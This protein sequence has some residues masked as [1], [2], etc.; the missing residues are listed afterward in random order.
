MEEAQGVRALPR[1]APAHG[2]T[3]APVVGGDPGPA[4]LGSCPVNPAFAVGVDVHEDQSFDQVREDELQ[5]ARGAMLNGKARC[6]Q[7]SPP[8]AP[9]PTAQA[10]H[11]ADV[12]LSWE[13]W[14][15]CGK[16]AWPPWPRHRRPGLPVPPGAFTVAQPA[17]ECQR[18]LFPMP[19]ADS[20]YGATP[21]QPIPAPGS[22]QTWPARRLLPLH[23]SQSRT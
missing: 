8:P 20:R 9:L 5:G 10:L 14:E 16:T 7:G 19:Q 3:R 21:G 15:T 17:P 11:G 22:P 13:R 2:A 1:L 4:H 18:Q 23:R 6:A 12:A